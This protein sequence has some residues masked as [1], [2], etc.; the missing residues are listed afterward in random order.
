[1]MGAR[2]GWFLPAKSTLIGEPTA[3]VQPF[4]EV[5]KITPETEYHLKEMEKRTT[6]DWENFMAVCH[7]EWNDLVNQRL[8]NIQE[9]AGFGKDE[10]MDDNEE[11]NNSEYNLCKGDQGPGSDPPRRVVW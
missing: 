5:N 9:G 7:K 11:D 1:M 8:D 2:G 3:F 10:V 4:L 6:A